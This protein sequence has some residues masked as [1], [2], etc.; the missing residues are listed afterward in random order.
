MAEEWEEAGYDSKEEY[1]QDMADHMLVVDNTSITKAVVSQA[2]KK[3]HE[4]GIILVPTQAQLLKS[5]DVPK[6]IS[7]QCYIIY[8]FQSTVDSNL[9]VNLLENIKEALQEPR[10]KEK[11]IIEG[12]IIRLVGYEIIK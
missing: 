5:Q 6:G 1:E 4:Y 12:N 11:C 10:Y 2:I 3:L 9:Q 7:Q 8:S